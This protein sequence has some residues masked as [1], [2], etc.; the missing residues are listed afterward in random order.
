MNFEEADRRYADLKRQN[1]SGNL[2]SIEFEAQLKEIMVVDGE[3]GW[4]S[5]HPQ[6]GDWYYYDGSTWVQ[7]T[8][9]GSEPTRPQPEP[10]RPQPESTRSAWWIG[11]S[12][13]SAIAGVTIIPFP[14]SLVVYILG[15][16]LGGY[17]ARQGGSRW[18]SLAAMV[19]NGVFLLGELIIFTVSGCT[20]L[21]C[22]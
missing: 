12:I 1:D 17:G 7:R 18:G 8:P 11:G 16:F 10:T 9:P 19:I 15:L 4:W 2:S 5:K 13:V 22:M 6:T 20:W 14:L 3:G 21:N